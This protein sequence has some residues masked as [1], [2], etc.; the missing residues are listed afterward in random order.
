M[1]FL[2]YICFEIYY[3]HYILFVWAHSCLHYYEHYCWLY[4]I[5]KLTGQYKV[6]QSERSNFMYVEFPESSSKDNGVTSVAHVMFLYFRDEIYCQIAKQLTQNP[7]KSSHAR[8]WILLSLCVGCFS[9][10]DK[11]GTQ[12]KE[13][14]IF[15]PSERLAA[16][17]VLRNSYLIAVCALPCQLLGTWGKQNLFSFLNTKFIL[18]LQ[19]K[20][21]VCLKMHKF[22][23]TSAYFTIWI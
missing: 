4:L 5:S 10:S 19:V 8:G 16:K 14:F 3:H 11:V 7:S 1:L 18:W 23:R 2:Q 20:R 13:T 12:E 6:L 21:S 15:T 17:M 9:P 22:Q